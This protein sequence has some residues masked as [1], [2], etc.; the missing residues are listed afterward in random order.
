[1]EMQQSDLG[2]LT[3]PFFIAYSLFPIPHSLIIIPYS[4]ITKPLTKNRFFLEE[5]RGKIIGSR[6]Q[7]PFTLILSP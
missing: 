7:H 6:Y 2:I 4:L 1:M 3:S 5:Q